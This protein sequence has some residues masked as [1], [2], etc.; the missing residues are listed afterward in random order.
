MQTIIGGSQD[1][2][3]ELISDFLEDAPL[4]IAAMQRAK[5]EAA[6]E[7]VRRAAHTLK[8]NCRDLG[9]LA[10]S[11]LCA[12]LEFDLSGA[13]IVDDLPSRIAAIAA[14][15]PEVKCALSRELSAAGSRS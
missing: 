3:N 8:S 12:E 9:A 15:W 10:M 2:L 13:S 6:L 7:I 5:G 11:Q 4:Q 14:L 1:D